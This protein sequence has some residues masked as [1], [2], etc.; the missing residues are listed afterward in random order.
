MASVDRFQTAAVIR[1]GVRALSVVGDRGDARIRRY[2][3]GLSCTAI[4]DPAAGSDRVRPV[5]RGDIVDSADLS[6]ADPSACRSAHS[7]P[8]R[9]R[10]DDGRSGGRD[11]H[12]VRS[13]RRSHR[14]PDR[15]G[16]RPP[17]VRR[18]LLL[19]A[20][21]SEIALW[22]PRS[23]YP[24][25]GTSL[26]TVRAERVRSAAVRLEHQTS[27]LAAYLDNRFL[28][29]VGSTREICYAYAVDHRHQ[30]AG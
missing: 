24:C 5:Y 3:S 22:Q 6:S 15:S 2:H 14:F 8:R 26:R 11:Q 19:P 7:E 4:G 9:N 28:H 21:P 18:N 27:S 29:T 17:P 23:P 12:C 1:S 16:T 20:K 13:A 25:A 30:I 10:R